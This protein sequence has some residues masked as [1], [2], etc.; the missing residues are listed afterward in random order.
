MKRLAARLT[1]LALTSAPLLAFAQDVGDDGLPK[2]T[3]D[4]MTIL[5]RIGDWLF[6]GL[7]IISVIMLIVA[8]YKYLFSQGSEE[9]TTSAKN[10]IVYAVIALAV[11]MLAGGIPYLVKSILQV[12]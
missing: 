2:T 6:T 7:L 5:G 3:K 8:G 10:T 11:A 12:K 4:V 1:V 9:Q